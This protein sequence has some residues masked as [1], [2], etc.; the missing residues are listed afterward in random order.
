MNSTMKSDHTQDRL[1]S[2]LVQFL[3]KELADEFIR[4]H[5]SVTY[6]KEAIIFLQG[7]PAHFI[8]WIVSGLVNLYR[9]RSDGDRTL[10]RLCGPG[11]VLGYA[12]F[13]D[14]GNRHLQ[15]FEAQALTKCTIALF[16]RE[17]A[18]TMLEKLDQQTLLRL[19]VQ[20]NT[21]WSSVAFWFAEILGYSF[22]Q[23]LDATLKDLATRFGVEDKRGMLL[24]MKLSHSDLAEMINGS[25]LIVARLITEMIQEQSLY[26]DGKRYI[27]RSAMLKN[28]SANAVLKNG[29][30]NA[31]TNGHTNG[32]KNCKGR[33]EPKSTIS[34]NL[35][36]SALPSGVAS[37][38]RFSDQFRHV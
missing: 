12:D 21:A 15:A 23:R 38:R 27:V 33:L 36:N 37:A 5:T 22:R 29:S 6:A 11:D 28:G 1:H 20:L 35:G 16:T 13:I 30:A 10:V 18:V 32:Q 34:M 9:P 24:P 19:I 8:F 31:V 25:F 4:H 2:Q 3:P 26:R 17:H 7:S 14:A